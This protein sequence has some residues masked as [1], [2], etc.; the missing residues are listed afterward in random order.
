[1]EIKKVGVVGCGLMGQGI[2]EVAARSGYDVVVCEVKRELLDKGLE[3]VKGSLSQAEARNKITPEEARATLSRISGA[4]SPDAFGECDIVVEAVVENL[5]VKKDVF[6]SLDKCCPPH[7][8]LASNTSAISI[9]DMA[10]VTRRPD[11]VIGLHFMNPVP[12]MK[13][14]EMV[15]SIITSQET[16]RDARHFV[17]SLGKMVVTAKDTPGFIINR[18]LVPYIFD[19]IRMLESGLASKEDIDK[20]MQFGLN[21]PMGPLTL[22][23]LTGLDTARN[24]GEAMYRETRDARYYPPVLLQ[25]MVAAGWLG[26]KTG[27]GFY[28]YR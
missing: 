6:Q 21:H 15:V 14:C 4:T 2:T 23:D 27:K 25:K 13:L 12:V 10:R 22:V 26:R 18:L 19:A 8:I 17:E 24:I 11:K 7:A 20:S 3:A 16:A 1:M 9:I 5:G 28:D